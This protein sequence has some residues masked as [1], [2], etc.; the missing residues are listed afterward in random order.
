MDGRLM[1]GPKNK[2][3]YIGHHIFLNAQNII[4]LQ[5]ISICVFFFFLPLHFKVNGKNAI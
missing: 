5:L 2:D 1:K 4:R 3:A